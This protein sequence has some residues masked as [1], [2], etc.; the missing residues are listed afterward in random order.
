MRRVE[1]AAVPSRA[2]REFLIA[3][4]LGT[5]LE[6]RSR[7]AQ[8]LS[9]ETIRLAIVREYGEVT[10]DDVVRPMADTIMEMVRITIE[11][12]LIAT[13]GRG[14]EGVGAWPKSLAFDAPHSLN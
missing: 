2:V 14:G 5:R 12:E 4:E 9:D 6:V 11:D 13:S 3:A 10:S 8:G 1:N 7:R